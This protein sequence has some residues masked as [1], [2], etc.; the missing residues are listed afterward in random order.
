MVTSLLHPWILRA[1]VRLWPT[2]WPWSMRPESRREAHT[3]FMGEGW[4]RCSQLPHPHS[5]G[6]NTPQPPLSWST[7]K[8]SSQ[9]SDDPAS[10][11]LG[12]LA[13]ATCQGHRDACASVF[14]M[15]TLTVCETGNNPHV[16]PEDSLNYSA[17][18]NREPLD[19]TLC[20]QGKISG[21]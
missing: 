11:Q 3:T 6:P 21:L 20:S 5:F 17:R 8:T 19:R 7:H 4:P 1:G 14:I 2:M 10:S 16:C 13:D 15:A 12:T 9:P 18:R